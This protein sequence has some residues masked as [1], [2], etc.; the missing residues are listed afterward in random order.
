[1]ETENRTSANRHFHI[2]WKNVAFFILAVFWVIIGYFNYA[3][4]PSLSEEI[5]C[6]TIANHP[7][8]LLYIWFTVIFA[9]VPSIFLWHLFLKWD[10]EK[11]KVKAAYGLS[12]LTINL[13][14][15]YLFIFGTFPLNM[16]QCM[17]DYTFARWYFAL[18]IVC[19]VPLL[20]AIVGATCGLVVGLIYLIG[21][22]L[23]YVIVKICRL[24]WWRAIATSVISL[25]V[26][27]VTDVELG[28]VTSDTVS[29]R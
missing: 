16:V 12:L 20:I 17:M 8:N 23:H 13:V 25:F 2:R 1:M 4:I 15:C 24:T 11:R 7:K 14:F 3:S 29:E 26:V 22:L 18:Y 10:N 9:T 27:Q 19:L 21:V 6:P 5:V 28:R